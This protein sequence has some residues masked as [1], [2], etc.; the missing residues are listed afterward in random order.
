MAANRWRFEILSGVFTVGIVWR[1][2][3]ESNT[4]SLAAMFR[5]SIAGVLVGAALAAGGCGDR[6]PT[7]KV[8]EQEQLK[9][10]DQARQRE[11]NNQ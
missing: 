1:S 4:M 3:S 10:L 5:V 11:W 9:E 7:D 8:T 6:A 2:N